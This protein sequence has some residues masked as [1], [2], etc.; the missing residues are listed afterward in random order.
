[1][2][3]KAGEDHSPKGDKKCKPK[4]EVSD[5]KHDSLNAGKKDLIRERGNGLRKKR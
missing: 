5:K 2:A 3:K 4:S 1:M